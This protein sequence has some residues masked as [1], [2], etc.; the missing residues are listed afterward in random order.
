M[1]FVKLYVYIGILRCNVYSGIQWQRNKEIYNFNDIEFGY[2]YI[3]INKIYK[4]IFI[5]LKELIIYKMYFE[6]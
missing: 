1:L 2:I 4:I 6:R 3:F 5:L